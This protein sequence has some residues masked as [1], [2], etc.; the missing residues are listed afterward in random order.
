MIHTKSHYFQLWP[1]K[2]FD[3]GVSDAIPGLGE[4]LIEMR[5]PGEAEEW[6]LLTLTFRAPSGMGGET[7]T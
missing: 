7:V 4:L 1:G 6:L 3:L 5:Q 2:S